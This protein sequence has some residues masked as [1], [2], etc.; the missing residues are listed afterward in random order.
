MLLPDQPRVAQMKH[1]PERVFQFIVKYKTTHDGCAPSLDEI[2][3]ACAISSKSIARY[4]LL[5]L[6]RGGK[7]RLGGIGMPRAILVVGGN[8]TLRSQD[9]PVG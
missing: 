1:D 6:A 4:Q 7:I 9:A 3:H 5:I 8:W 2:M